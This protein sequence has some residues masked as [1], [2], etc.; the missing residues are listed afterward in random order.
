[1][2]IILTQIANK[3]ISDQNTAKFSK[4]MAKLFSVFEVVVHQDAPKYISKLHIYWSLKDLPT[5]RHKLKIHDVKQ[6]LYKIIQN[7]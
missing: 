3:C 6:H 7:E 1:M 4:S 2:D 5:C